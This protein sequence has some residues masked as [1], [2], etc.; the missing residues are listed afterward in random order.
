MRT[1]TFAV[2]LSLAALACGPPAEPKTVSMRMVGSPANA[3]VT[4]DDIFVGRLDTVAA[5]G[6]ALPVGTHHVTVEAPG[7]LPW[8]KVVEA[9]E[10]A[11]PVR[12]EVRLVATPD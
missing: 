7:Y 2:G 10:G 4:I 9:K 5:R 11:G 8:D 6:V 12:L 3:S 1:L